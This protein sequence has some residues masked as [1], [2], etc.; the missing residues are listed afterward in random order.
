M[1]TKT[2]IAGLIGFFLGGLLVA[3]VATA[4]GYSEPAQHNESPAQ[5]SHSAK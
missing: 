1:D 5:S 3:T 4:T 2:L